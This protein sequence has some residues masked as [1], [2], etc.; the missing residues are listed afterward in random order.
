MHAIPLIILSCSVALDVSCIGERSLRMRPNE[1]LILVLA[2]KG[3]G[4]A[5]MNAETVLA[6]FF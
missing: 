4:G 2:G 5:R 6:T 3:A 1:F